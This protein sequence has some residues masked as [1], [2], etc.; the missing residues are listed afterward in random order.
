MVGDVV[1]QVVVDV[2]GVFWCGCYW[3]GEGVVEDYL[4]GFQV[5][6]VGCQFVGQLGDVFGWVV[7][8]CG[9]DVR[10]FDYVIVVEDCW[11]LL[12]VDIV[13][14][15]GLVVY[16]YVGVGGVV[17]DGVEDFVCDFCLWVDLLD[18]CIDDFQ[19]W[20]YLFGGFEYVEQGVVWF[21]QW[22]VEDECQFYFD[23]WYDEVLEGDV[24]VF[25]EEYVV[26]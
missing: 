19:C 2:E 15:Y 24:V 26:E 16:Y 5:D 6:V 4:V 18:V 7:E 1:E 9:G 20:D 17:G 8:Y 25:F 13:W 12:Q 11:Y 22:F 3:V 23:L 10:F 14:L 21:F